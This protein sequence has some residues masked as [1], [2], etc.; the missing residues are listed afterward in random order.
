MSATVAGFSDETLN[1]LSDYFH[2]APIG[3]HMTG[4]DGTIT[5]ANLAELALLGY[6]DHADEYIGRDFAAFHADP[7][8]LQGVLDRLAAG[9]AVIGH[10]A[11][12]VRRDGSVQRVVLYVNARIEDGVFRGARCFTF[13]HPDQLRPDVAELAALTDQSIESRRLALTAEQRRELYR[14]LHDFFENGPVGLHIVGGDGL[15]KHANKAE[16]TTLGYDAGAYLGAHIARFHAEQ[17]VIDGMLETLVAGTPLVNFGATLFRNDGSRLPVLIY[18]NSR[19][20]DGSFVNTRCFTV[21]APGAQ[22]A[23]RVEHF[24][25][26]RNED[27]GFTLPGREA[28]R[29]APSPMTVA[30]KYIASRKRPEESLGFLARVSQVLGAARPLDALLRDA[31]ALCVP[32]LADVVSIDLVSGHLAHACS[33]SLEPRVAAIVRQ[34]AASGRTTD[35]AADSAE[36]CL[37]TRA[38]VAAASPRATQLRELGI[39]SMIVAPLMIRGESIGTVAVLR[40]DAPSRRVFGPADR[41]LAEEFAR[42]I[43][44]A[45]EIDR[46]SRRA[47]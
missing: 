18:S 14:D 33:A 31:A 21:P 24:S 15:I 16:L 45:V 26:P 3:L 19:M 30:L 23:D 20:R 44:F 27:F 34:R 25:W 2:G 35:P 17:R 28:A 6:R 46:L 38:A 10:E 43:S 9:Q 36:A 11:S 47:N 37:D 42:R 8:A 39:R 5:Q 40:D 22:T 7:E 12:L 29:E 4:A 41:A 32:F 13:P 1:D